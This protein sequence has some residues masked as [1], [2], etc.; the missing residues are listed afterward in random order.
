MNKIIR[1]YN[2]NRLSFWIIVI[3]IVFGLILLQVLNGFAKEEAQKRH[4]QSANTNNV[5]TT[6]EQKQ[7]TKRSEPIISGDT[8]TEEQRKT[9]SNVI[10]SFL[11]YCINGN[12]AQAYNLLSSDCKEVYYKTQEDFEAYYCKNKFTQYKKYD[13]ELWNSSGSKVYRIKLYEDMLSTGNVSSKY[14]EDYYTITTDNG[15]KRLNINSYIG[16]D[17]IDKSA[18]KDDLVVDVKYVDRF[19]ENII[20]T[21]TLKNNGNKNIILDTKTRPNSVYITNN[22]QTKYSALLYENLQNDLLIKPEEEKTI[23][24]KFAIN[25]GNDTNIESLIFSDVVLDENNKDIKTKIEINI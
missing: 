9:N 6:Y 1:Y 17:T 22:Y 20:Y 21:I 15:Q 13:Y 12:I 24:I 8:L 10:D 4:E 2:Q 7:N 3:I 14:I 5:S 11:E 23:T 18:T 19:K 25:Y 16:R